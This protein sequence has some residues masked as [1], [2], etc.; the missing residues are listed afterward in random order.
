MDKTF[1]IDEIK[2]AEYLFLKDILTF[3]DCLENTYEYRVNLFVEFLSK[4]YYPGIKIYTVSFLEM[5]D[6]WLSKYYDELVHECLISDK[7]A[8]KLKNIDNVKFKV[9]DE[10]YV[11]GHSELYDTLEK[12][13]G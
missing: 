3:K 2:E 11:Y 12:I 7:E 5:K 6:P 8:E 9:T 1:T 4:H 13:R 10:I